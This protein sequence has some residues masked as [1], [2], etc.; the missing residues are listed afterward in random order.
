VFT[1]PYRPTV[2][3]LP[4]S[5]GACYRSETVTVGLA[6]LDSERTLTFE[7]PASAE[8]HALLLTNA[9]LR[10]ANGSPVPN[11]RGASNSDLAV[12]EESPGSGPHGVELRVDSYEDRA[13][14]YWLFGRAFEPS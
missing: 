12:V 9:T 2:T 13:Y 7:G 3:P 10:D 4:P 1:G 14:D 6:D 5:E 11:V 8:G